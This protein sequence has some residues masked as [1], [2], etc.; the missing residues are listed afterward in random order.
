[1]LFSILDVNTIQGEREH[2]SKETPLMTDLDWGDSDVRDCRTVTEANL[3]VMW[4]HPGQTKLVT[5]DQNRGTN[6]NGLS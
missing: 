4:L 5:S 2:E 6:Q 1:M 3:P